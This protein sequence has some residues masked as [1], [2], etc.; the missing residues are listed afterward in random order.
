LHWYLRQ[1]EEVLIRVLLFTAGTKRS[2]Q[3]ARRCLLEG[4]KVAAIGI[5]VT[6]DY[7]RTLP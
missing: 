3:V 2:A 4:I 1:L 6:L 5:K 7:R